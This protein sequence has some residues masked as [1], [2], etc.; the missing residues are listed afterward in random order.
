MKFFVEN[1]KFNATRRSKNIH[2]PPLWKKVW[3]FCF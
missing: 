3:G 2:F 1:M